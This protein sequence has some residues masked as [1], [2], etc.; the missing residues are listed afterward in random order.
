MRIAL[1]TDTHWGVR[2]D[3]LAFLDY[4][5]KF[6][7]NIFFPE[8]DKRG[9]STVLHLG[10]IVDRRK[11]ISYVTLRRLKEGFI[12][13]CLYRNIDLHVIVGNHDVPYKNTN[14]INAM[15]EL[16]DS[17]NVKYYSEVAEVLFD[18]VPHAIIPWINNGNYAST[19]EFMQNTEAQV[20]FGHFE[21]AGCL[22]DRGNINDHGLKISDFKRFD[23]VM[24][25]HFHHKSTTGNIDYLGCP[26]ELTWSDYQDP[27][28]FHIYDTETRQLEFI[29]NPYSMFHKV[30]YNDEGKTME[31]LL[32]QE[33]SAY[34]G[35]Y[36]KVVKNSNGNPYWFDKFMDKLLKA[37]PISIQIVEDHLNLDLDDDDDLVNEAEDTMTILSKY[38]D[39]MPD[40]IPKKKLDSLMKSLY[41]EALHF[42]I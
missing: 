16:F 10:D 34:E 40:N 17:T 33:F 9:I 27:K 8:L 31:Q 13:P 20:V 42:E 23:R 39:G 29:R 37:D 26:Y 25:G 32:D 35:T 36:V 5:D 21:I 38:I 2:N 30:F 4:F 1:V 28:G 24:S 18:D 12:E 22:M 19:M 7:S 6:Y 14:E 15:Q 3:N 41:T 11:Y